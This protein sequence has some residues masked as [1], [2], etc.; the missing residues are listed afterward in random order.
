MSHEGARAGW[1]HFDATTNPLGTPV[2]IS[3]AVAA[4]S[5]AIPRDLDSEDAVAHLAA[6]AGVGPDAILLTAGATEA[7]ALVSSTFAARRNAV[8]V[9]PTHPAY[10]RVAVREDA[11]LTRFVAEPPAFDPPWE[12]ESAWLLDHPGALFACDPN[13]PTGRALGGDALRR[14]IHQRLPERTRVVLDQSFAP[15]SRPSLIEAESVAADNVILIRSFAPLNAT[16]GIRLGYVIAGPRT[17]A[18]LRARQDPWSVG[19]HALAVARV[20]SW[21]L[22]DDARARI[23]SWRS[24]LAAGLVLVGLEPRPSETNFVLVRVG[25]SATALVDALA[26]VR[27]AVRSCSDFDLPDHVRLTVRPPDEQDRLF[28]ALAAARGSIGW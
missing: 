22:A 18:A 2:A 20:A 5:Y 12:Q 14:L 27:I 7:I 24:R 21:T 17:V 9:G 4:A 3:E 26:R 6:D 23:L 13:N 1:L 15:F 10:A 8:V 19:A 25:P 11:E 16:P 28:E